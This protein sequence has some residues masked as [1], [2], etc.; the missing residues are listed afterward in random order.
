MNM[1]KLESKPDD[2]FSP[3]RGSYQMSGVGTVG[4]LLTLT[5]DILNFTITSRLTV[6]QVDLFVSVS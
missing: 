3:L 1:Q 5:H 6:W 4:C 2:S